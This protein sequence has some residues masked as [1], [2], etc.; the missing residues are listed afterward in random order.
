[1]MRNCRLSD[2]NVVQLC[3][4]LCDQFFMFW[5]IYPETAFNG[6]IELAGCHILLL[7]TL[8]MLII[9]KKMKIIINLIQMFRKLL[10]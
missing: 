5:E 9:I 4:S 6:G 2:S 8:F 10:I 3:D 1:M 7:F